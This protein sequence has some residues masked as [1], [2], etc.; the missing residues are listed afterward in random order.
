M[1]VGRDPIWEDRTA[2]PP[3]DPE[4]LALLGRILDELARIAGTLDAISAK[5]DTANGSLVSLDRAQWG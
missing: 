3:T 1:T 5:L 4:V 2:P